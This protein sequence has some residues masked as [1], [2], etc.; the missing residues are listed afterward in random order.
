MAFEGQRTQA[1]ERLKNCEA[2]K[3][4][5]CVYIAASTHDARYTRSCVASIRYFY[6]EIPI[7][8]LV[9]RD[10]Q[11]GLLDELRRY[12]DVG[13]ADI[14]AG[15]Y[16]WGFV[17]LE[18][19]F[20]PPGERFLV[21]DSDT[22][23]AGP[24]LEA[25]TES[26]APFLV[27]EEEQA[28]ADTKRL[29]Y[30][31]Q[32]VRRF[33]PNAQPPQFVFNSGQWFGTAGVLTRHDFEPWI[34]WTMPRRTSP[35]EH[36][37]SGEQGLLNYILNQK[38]MLEGLAVERRN[39]MRW[40]PR[41]MQG[42]NLESVSRHAAPPVVI[43]WAGAAKTRR[44]RDMIGVDLLAHFERAYYQRLPGGALR[45][46]FVVSNNYLVRTLPGRVLAKLQLR[47]RLAYFRTRPLE[48]GV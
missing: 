30:D 29:Y 2:E 32:K 8:L 22:V 23:L 40:P 28:E 4:I 44:R 9:G 13:V 21:L 7:R 10:L 12:W 31:W 47:K 42:V 26:R 45:R 6:P 39:I 43:H 24:V 18:P 36:F 48:P 20:G 34:E 5:D 46:L 11:R 37:M 35:P 38:A 15:D 16:G 27:D 17:K 14:P 33:D 41:S 1:L 3:G 19:L 25:F